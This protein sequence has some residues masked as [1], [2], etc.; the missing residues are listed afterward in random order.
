QIAV[1]NGMDFP[2]ALS[3]AAHAAKAEMPIL[4]T[5]SDWMADSTIQVIDELGAAET[6][7]VGGET[8]LTDDLLAEL[9][10]ATRI[11]GHDRY[12]TNIAVNEHFD[13]DS[14]YMY[15]ATGQEYADALTGAVLAAKKDSTVLL[16]HNRVPDIVGNYIEKREVKRL[17]V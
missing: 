13:V 8:V 6:V 2:D 3:V 12:E 14:D 15:V 7:A 5:K 11:A 4:L 1:A 17:S 10:D 16:V 9:P